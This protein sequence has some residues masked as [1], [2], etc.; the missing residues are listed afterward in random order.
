[1]IQDRL[2]YKTDADEELQPVDVTLLDRDEIIANLGIEYTLR[3]GLGIGLGAE[4]SEAEFLDDPGK[5]SNSGI[6]PLRSPPDR[7]QVP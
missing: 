2:R 5:R 4:Y 7:S 1:M 6:S 3:N